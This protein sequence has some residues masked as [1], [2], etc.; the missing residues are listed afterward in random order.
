M[1]STHPTGLKDW[2]LSHAVSEAY[3]E[4]EPF[5]LSVVSKSPCDHSPALLRCGARLHPRKSQRSI[6]QCSARWHIGA[7]AV[8]R[9]SRP[10]DASETA[11]RIAAIRGCSCEAAR[12]GHTARTLGRD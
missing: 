10:G 7:D 11:A 5:R 12:V 1:Q 9:P 6:P 3:S 4:T 2:S 8:G